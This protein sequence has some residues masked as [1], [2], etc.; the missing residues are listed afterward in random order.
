MAS[1]RIREDALTWLADVQRTLPN[2][3]IWDL[4]YFCVMA[5]LSSG[6]SED[7][8]ATAR[9]REMVDYFVNNYKPAESFL[10]GMLIVAELKRGRIDLSEEGEVRS[11]FRNLVD[12]EGNNPFTTEGMNRLNAY[13]NG[14]YEYLAESIEQKPQSAEEFLRIYAGLVDEA[15]PL[16]PFAA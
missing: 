10:V 4:Y 1:F 5:G 15:I 7:L 13:A 11:V 3:E 14:G 16:G 6:R 2:C 12:G 8:S 9:S